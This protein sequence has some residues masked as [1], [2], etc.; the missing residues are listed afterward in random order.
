[1]IESSSENRGF[2]WSRGF[3]TLISLAVGLITLLPAIWLPKYG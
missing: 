2:D 3:G 1:M